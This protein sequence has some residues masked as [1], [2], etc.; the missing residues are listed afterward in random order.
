MS[1]ENRITSRKNASVP[2]RGVA[3]S[4]GTRVCVGWERA[5]KGINE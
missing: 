2:F 3:R 4:S 5:G 1:S